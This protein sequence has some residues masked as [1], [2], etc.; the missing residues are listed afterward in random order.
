MSMYT[1]PDPHSHTPVLE[2]GAKLGQATHAMILVHGRGATA[3]SMLQFATEFGELNK[4]RILAPQANMNTWYPYSFLVETNNNQPGIKSGLAKINTLVSQLESEGFNR[5]TIA[6]LGFSQ[7]ACLSLE[8]ASRNP[9]R[10]SQVFGLSGGVIGDVA[11][12]KNYPANM[13]GLSVFLGCSDVDFH[14]PV[15]RVHE[16]E[17][18]FSSGG[19]KVD[20]RIYP[21]M[22]HMVN[23]DE[24]SVVKSYLKLKG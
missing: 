10:I 17:R 2:A 8:F 23:E 12:L 3:Q 5:E 9:Q 6:L 14:I 4:V 22:G 11:E 1:D 24:L 16:T 20:K 7:G 19:A 13:N 18:I 21:G 15:D